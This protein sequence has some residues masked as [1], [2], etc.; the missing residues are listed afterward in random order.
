MLPLLAIAGF[1]LFGQFNK[2]LNKRAD[3]ELLYEEVQWVNYLEATT[4]GGSRFLLQTP[5]LLIYPSDHEATGYPQLST[6]YGNKANEDIKIP[7]RQLSDVVNINGLP[8]QIVIRKSQEQKL[9]LVAN[10]IYIMLLVFAG[11]LM[12]TLVFN[13]IISKKL[14]QPFRLSLQKIRKI[15]LPQMAT[16]RFEETDTKEFNELNASLNL[17]VN[18]IHSDYLNMKEFTEDAAHEMQTPLAVA[19]SKMELL[20]QE[21]GL[22]PEQI[23]TI[24][25]AST[26]LHRLG[27]LNQSLLLLAKIENQQYEAKE[28]ID[29]AEVTKKY[30]RLF[31]EII[32]EKQITVHTS[33]DDRFELRLHPFLADSMIS[34]LIGNAV[35]YNFT[36]GRLV[37]SVD[38]DQY[39]ISNTSQH[40]PL[41]P[42]R[43]FRRFTAL[44]EVSHHS[45]GLGLAIVKRIADTHQLQIR[46]EA[47]GEMHRF[48]ITRSGA[49]A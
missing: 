9:V 42:D 31:D 24:A 18:K 30:L 1:L 32:R 36:G 4:A 5:E 20:L 19:Q 7:F 45:T 40:P 12:A 17:M 46:Y 23:A 39:C 27:K 38:A 33:F 6:V 34:N 47:E 15:E 26:A 16:I 3:Q 11:L 44:A 21:P 43:L 8:Y 28:M 14:W 10:I 22:S 13:W 41:D 29:L 2:Q 25:Q 37:I 49:K 48:C 35:K